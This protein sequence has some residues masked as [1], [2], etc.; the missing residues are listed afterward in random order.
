VVVDCSA[1]VE[2]LLESELFGH[3]RGSFT[4]AVSDK[5][6]AF[7]EADG[8]TL[9]LDEISDSTLTMQQ[10][11]RRVLQEGQIRRVGDNVYRDVDVRVVC[12]T[13]RKLT[14]EVKAGRFLHDLYHRI[15]Q[16]P[17][18]LPAIRE[19]REDIPIIVESF[20]LAAG[21]RKNPPVRGIEP[22]VLSLLVSRDWHDNN[23]REI[24][25][26]VELA[27]DLSRQELIDLPTME[28]T[29]QIREEPYTLHPVPEALELPEGDCVLLDPQRAR[30]AFEDTSENASKEDRPYYRMQR[31]F[32][33]KLIV[34]SLRYKGWKLRPAAR[35]LGISPVKLRQDFRQ[36]L[37]HLLARF[38]EDGE[39]Q[40]SK[41]LDMPYE[42]LSRKLAD[43]GI[44][45]VAAATSGE[46]ASS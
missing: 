25:N 45:V 21:S 27:V 28:R 26:V 18:R 13:N 3:T 16:F 40:V 12:A 41:I 34:E 44:R 46:D 4:G 17:I 35:L 22:D 39:H 7:E 42:T 43:L 9:F 38:G 19:R 29:L 11:L 32:S 10:K 14:E 5:V 1:L 20:I 15:H 30:I 2:S 36:Y 31:E 24:K 8:G 6:G 33:G 37:E 23:V